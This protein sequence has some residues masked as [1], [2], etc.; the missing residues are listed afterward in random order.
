MLGSS[1]VR[2]AKLGLLSLLGTAEKDPVA[3]A[4]RARLAREFAPTYDY[5]RALG[6]DHYS[7]DAPQDAR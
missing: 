3:P 7:P 2:R 5:L 6:F 4:V 1:V